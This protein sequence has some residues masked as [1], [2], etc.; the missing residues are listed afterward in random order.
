MHT[1]RPQTREA[2]TV[3]ELLVVVGIIT[4][5]IAIVL[6]A[7]G[8]AQRRG[9]KLRETNN[10]RQVGIAW[11]LYGNNNDG[12]ALPGYLD[13]AVQA[14]SDRSQ[15]RVG[16]NVTYKFPDHSVIP[17]A[18]TYNLNDGNVAGPWTWRLMDMI[19]P[20]HDLIHG[21]ADEDD[22][23]VLAMIGE[24]DEIA[25]TPFVEPALDRV[26]A[27]RDYQCRAFTLFDDEVTH[28]Q[29]KRASSSADESIRT[30]NPSPASPGS[31]CSVGRTAI[32]AFG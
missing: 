25:E 1:H 24:A 20:N 17:P 7:L 13:V 9:A 5:L 4:L 31:L 16:W 27:M 6:P 8:G 18:P 12:A 14:P 32:F 26:D 30:S 3:I 23:S 29:L 28:R 15:G 11:N 10:L 21:Y 22:G 2:F 19:G